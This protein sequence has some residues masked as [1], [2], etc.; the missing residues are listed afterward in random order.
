MATKEGGRAGAGVGTRQS[1][2]H[3]LSGL[4]V[5]VP[6]PVPAV[7]DKFVSS[8]ECGSPSIRRP[9]R[10]EQ[11]SDLF[12]CC[13]VLGQSVLEVLLGPA[14]SVGV[15]ASASPRLLTA[16]AAAPASAHGR[17]VSITYR[18]SW[19][20]L[21]DLCPRICLRTGNVLVQ[22]WEHGCQ[23]RSVISILW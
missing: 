3:D 1:C 7:L 18:L 17:A 10:K 8:R 6:V 21:A 2:C 5:P 13:L 20:R 11:I 16:A 4:P 9:I 23:C 15:W 19:I 12:C 14:D 22:L